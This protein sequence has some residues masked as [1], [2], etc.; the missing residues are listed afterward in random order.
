MGTVINAIGW[1]LFI[2]LVLWGGIQAEK[3]DA[4]PN[5]YCIRRTGI[6]TVEQV[7]VCEQ[8]LRKENHE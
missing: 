7:Q 6:L 1:V 2:A 5:N 8:R 4:D 3:Y